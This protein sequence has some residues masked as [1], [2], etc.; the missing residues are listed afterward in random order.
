MAYNAAGWKNAELG[1][2]GKM[3]VA[4]LLLELEEHDEAIRSVTYFDAFFLVIC[5]CVFLWKVFV[6]VTGMCP[7]YTPLPDVIFPATDLRQTPI[8]SAL[9]MRMTLSLQTFRLHANIGY[10]I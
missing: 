9:R 6:C 8:S 7:C 3:S 1:Y 2:A 4:S 5:T 10:V